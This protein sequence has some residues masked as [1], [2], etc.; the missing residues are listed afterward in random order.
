LNR[1]KE[2]SHW[3]LRG[4]HAVL[5]RDGEVGLGGFRE[6]GGVDLISA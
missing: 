6:R 5:E 1:G 3:R 4:E 2:V